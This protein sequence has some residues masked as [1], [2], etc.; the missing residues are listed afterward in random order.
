[1]AETIFSECE[2][3]GTSNRRM[4]YGC[5]CCGTPLGISP[6]DGAKGA[7]L[8]KKVQEA[9]MNGGSGLVAS[10]LIKEIIPWT[11]SR[12]Q[13]QCMRVALAQEFSRMDHLLQIDGKVL[14]LG[15]KWPDAKFVNAVAFYFYRDEKLVG[16]HIEERRKKSGRV[17]RNLETVGGADGR[18]ITTKIRIG[19][20]IEADRVATSYRNLEISNLEGER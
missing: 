10:H 13:R 18:G 1:M 7:V 3:C 19:C 5:I 2:W 14:R 11:N 16:G 12:I 9:F 20:F 8:E 15:W 4:T 17:G 6:F